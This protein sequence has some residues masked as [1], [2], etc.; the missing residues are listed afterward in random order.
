[1]RRAWPQEADSW[2]TDDA[3]CLRLS[4]KILE[5]VWVHIHFNQT[6]CWVQCHFPSLPHRSFAVQV[7][8]T[9][10]KVHINHKES[11]LKWLIAYLL[12]WLFRSAADYFCF[13]KSFRECPQ[14]ALGS[15]FAEKQIIHGWCECISLSKR[16]LPIL[17]QRFV[18]SRSLVKSLR[19]H[20]SHE[21]SFR[22]SLFSLSGR[23][24]FSGVDA[25]LY[26][27]LLS[28]R[29]MFTLSTAAFPAPLIEYVNGSR[30]YFKEYL[31]NHMWRSLW[32]RSPLKPFVKTEKNIILEP[33]YLVRTCCAPWCC[34]T[35][36]VSPNIHFS[37][38][39]LVHA[40]LNEK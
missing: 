7:Q 14:W 32:R 34:L 5:E 11:S 8:V 19:C 18:P 25:T 13:P 31:W 38:V 16:C 4:P 26:C 37:D 28:W 30:N 10:V 9:G 27:L 6:P 23:I 24:Q 15:G 2:N 39:L 21:S 12:R 3:P 33:N 40:Y 22:T 20:F 1:M 17:N 35:W 29:E 36:A